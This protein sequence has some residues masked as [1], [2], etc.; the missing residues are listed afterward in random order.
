MTKRTSSIFMCTLGAALFSVSCEGMAQ[1]TA[2]TATTGAS[3]AATA[4]ASTAVVGTQ[5]GLK[6][7]A[8]S[9][10]L[11]HLPPAYETF[12]GSQGNMANLVNGLRLGQPF[13]LTGQ[14]T[15]GASVT[16]VDTPTRPMGYGN[17]TRTLT[18]TRRE[19]AS[20]GITQPTPQELKAALTGGEVTT[21]SGEVRLQ[22]VLTLRRQ[23]MGWGR[24]AHTLLVAPAA[25]T[26][27]GARASVS[28]AANGSIHAGHEE[29]HGDAGIVSALGG[30]NASGAEDAH[31][32][33][34]MHKVI[35]A[36]DG[37][38]AVTTA[39]GRAA[40]VA[41][42]HGET[43]GV[44]TAMGAIGSDDAGM[45]SAAG[46]AG[47]SS[48]AMAHAPGFAGSASAGITT[49][50]GIGAGHGGGIMLGRGR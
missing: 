41:S 21:A 4:N 26:G 33:I 20:A 40:A 27:T 7:A 6:S 5:S 43:H 13:S 35:D 37:H 42:V 18:L 16:V 1:T 23:H 38:G 14:T 31:A 12:A 17:I 22:G 8:T 45:V 10:Y 47:V 19:L 32:R 24:I 34:G 28:A 36:D 11:A 15:T 3:T 50:M 25:S 49:G 46:G 39:L 9:H 48:G 2:A 29:P 44:T 30:G